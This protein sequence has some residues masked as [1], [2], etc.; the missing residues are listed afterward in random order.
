MFGLFGKKKE[1]PP[2]ELGR[3]SRHP[4]LP[5][6]LG[7][8]DKAAFVVD[9]LIGKTTPDLVLELPTDSNP[10][11][12]DAQ[13][14]IDLG[15]NVHLHRFYCEED[16]WLQIKQSGGAD[17]YSSFDEILL[18]GFGDVISPTTQAEFEEAAAPIGEKTYVYA[19]KTY[20]RVFG[21]E[22]SETSACPEFTERVYPEKADSY[23][24]KH[25]VMM[26]SREIPGSDRPELLLVSVETDQTNSIRIV[27]SVGVE[28]HR[29]DLTIT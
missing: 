7:L 15:D 10:Q 6:P 28:L 12:I 18:F 23:E 16:Y 11:M 22:S 13:G 25:Q 29:S 20:T 1:V 26:Y 21:T 14:L 4:G 27:H 2:P 3:K 19:D 24:V 17:E 9:P 8:S 5:S